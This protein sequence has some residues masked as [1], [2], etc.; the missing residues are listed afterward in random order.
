MHKNHGITKQ[1]DIGITQSHDPETAH[2][3]V[4]GH[5]NDWNFPRSQLL[6]CISGEVSL[7]DRLLTNNSEIIRDR[8][9]RKKHLWL[10]KRVK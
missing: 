1:K 5:I 8:N 9:F 10:R 7:Y 2:N 3:K 6:I 4:V